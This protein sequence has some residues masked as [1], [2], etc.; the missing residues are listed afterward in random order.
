MEAGQVGEAAGC[1]AGTARC[2]AHI[3]LETAG[4]TGLNASCEL[5]V[6]VSLLPLQVEGTLL[7]PAAPTGP[8]RQKSDGHSGQDSHLCMHAC[9]K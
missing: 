4:Q 2:H 1:G 8:A 9:L 5:A 3:P 6:P 7:A